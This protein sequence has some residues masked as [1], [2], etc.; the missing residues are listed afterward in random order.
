MSLT[1]EIIGITCTA[2]GHHVMEVDRHAGRARRKALHRGEASPDYL[3]MRS[4]RTHP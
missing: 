4:V 1:G 3:A 2:D